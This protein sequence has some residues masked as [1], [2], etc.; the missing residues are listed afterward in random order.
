MVL[1]MIFYS[2]DASSAALSPPSP[3]IESEAGF[4]PAAAGSAAR[5][6]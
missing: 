5:L 3:G 2:G 4:V 1:W 6:H